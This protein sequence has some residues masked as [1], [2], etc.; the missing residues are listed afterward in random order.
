MGCQNKLVP[1]QTWVNCLM[2]TRTPPHWFHI[3]SSLH[4][5]AS[6]LLALSLIGRKGVL[7]FV[8]L[9]PCTTKGRS[10]IY[11]GHLNPSTASTTVESS[12]SSSCNSG[13]SSPSS[14]SRIS[15]STTSGA[16]NSTYS[17]SEFVPFEDMSDVWQEILHNHAVRRGACCDRLPAYGHATHMYTTSWGMPSNDT[18]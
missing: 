13:S 8:A 17:T 14:S 18:R 7:A 11:S 3:E 6:P 9:H 5:W 15:N 10:G 1:L 4:S 12:S 2:C 16:G